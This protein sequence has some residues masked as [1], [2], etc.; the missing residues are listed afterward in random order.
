MINVSKTVDF[1]CGVKFLD[2]SATALMV[3]L[4]VFNFNLIVILFWSLQL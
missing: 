1:G 4:I 3:A 2:I